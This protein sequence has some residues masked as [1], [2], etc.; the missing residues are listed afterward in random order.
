MKSKQTGKPKVFHYSKCS[1]CRKALAYL[2]AHD[3]D[4]EL[5][6][7]VQ[8]PPSKAELRRAR[9]LGGLPVQKLFNTS[10]QSYR[11]GGFSARLPN[12]SE[13]E[14]LDA[15]AADGKLVKRPLVL[16]SDFALVGF[17]P[18]AYAARFG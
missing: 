2:D 6:D 17:D 7:I 5:V 3:V 14:A 10:G 12:L 11:E 13:S 16:G 15:L 18:A 8:T 1:T 9:E 4:Y